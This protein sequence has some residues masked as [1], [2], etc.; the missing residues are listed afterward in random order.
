MTIIPV[1]TPTN[2]RIIDEYQAALDIRLDIIEAV[3]HGPVRLDFRGV[4]WIETAQLTPLACIVKQLRERGHTIEIISPKED[5]VDDWFNVINFPEGTTNPPRRL[6]GNQLPLLRIDQRADPDIDAA[7]DQIRRLVQKQVDA[8]TN[9]IMYPV[10]E[11]IDN[12]NEH[13]QSR[14]GFVMVQNY[15]RN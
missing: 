15:P 11:I 5:A 7:T 14:V 2:Q 3:E 13:S 6:R 1:T 9:P 10:Q 8:P 12:V 4:S